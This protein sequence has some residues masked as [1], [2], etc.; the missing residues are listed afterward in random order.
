MLVLVLMPSLKLSSRLVVLSPTQLRAATIPQIVRFALFSPPV[1]VPTSETVPDPTPPSATRP[2]SGPWS[3]RELIRS[4]PHRVTTVTLP[5]CLHTPQC[6]PILH[7]PPTP[8][9]S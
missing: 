5:A 9:T 2:G 6:Y 8:N 4:C 1:P 7:Q 3:T